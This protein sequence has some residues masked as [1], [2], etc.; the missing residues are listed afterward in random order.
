MK[1]FLNYRCHDCGCKEG[2]LH[3]DGCDMERCSVCG[4]QALICFEHCHNGNGTIR[5]GYKKIP[6]IIT[7]VCCV[8]CLEPYPNFFHLPDEEWKNT[9]PK[10]LQN[11][12][13]CRSC[14]N[15]IKK[16]MKKGHYEKKIH[17]KTV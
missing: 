9:V 3:L 4:G 7:P 6:Y 8:R 17:C 5:K 2:E 10:E 16:W 13:L 14:Y 11:E 15:L 1:T 12:I